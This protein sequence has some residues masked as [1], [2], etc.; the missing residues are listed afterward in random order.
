MSTDPSAWRLG[1]QLEEA[2]A[3][4]RLGVKDSIAIR[5]V[6]TTVGSRVLERQVGPQLRDAVVVARLRRAGWRVV[7][8]TNLVEL[9]YGTHGVNPFFG[10]PTNAADPARVPGGSSSGSA[11]G[12]ALGEL[13][14]AL[15][16]DTGGSVRIPAAANGIVGLKTSWGSLPLDG[17]APLAPSLDTVGILARDIATLARGLEALG[18]PLRR[19]TRRLAAL[20]TLET[21]SDAAWGGLVQQAVTPPVDLAAVHRAGSVVLDVEAS[22]S[23]G[24]LLEQGHRLDPWVRRRLEAAGSHKAAA[25]LEA[26]SFLEEARTSVALWLEGEGIV[27]AAPTLAEPPPLLASWNQSLNGLTL[28]VN[29]LGLPALAVPVGGAHRAWRETTVPWSLQ[30]VGP[31]GSE[32]DLLELAASLEPLASSSSQ[33]STQSRSAS[34]SGGSAT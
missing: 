10:T 16:T 33:A 13:D 5:G 24:W 28:W 23:W 32:A 25:Y 18:V 22:A 14:L 26:R 12:V 34:T 11:V 3:P 6:P 4:W 21:S 1:A 30:L 9:A 27:L 7:A 29:A 31:P 20:E 8:R 17:V 15:G 19:A 2:V